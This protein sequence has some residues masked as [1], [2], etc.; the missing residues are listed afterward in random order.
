M[1]PRTWR[2]W[3]SGISC[4]C[5]AARPADPEF[6]NLDRILLAATSRAVPRAGGH[7]SSSR[8]RHCCAGTG[9][10][11]Q[12]WTFA[13]APFRA[14]AAG[15]EL[16]PGAA[17]RPGEPPLGPVR[18]RGELRKLGIRV[19]ATTI[20]RCCGD[21]AVAPRRRSGPPGSPS[22]GAGRGDRRLRLLHG[23]DGLAADAV[24]PVLPGG[25]HPPGFRRR[26]HDVPDSAVGHP[27]SPNLTW[28][29]TIWRGR[30]FLLRDRDAK[31]PAA[32]DAVF[33]PKPPRSSARRWGLQRRTRLPSG[34]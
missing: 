3:C 23:G 16:S 11:R 32:F 10:V 19:G 33:R 22:S 20:R 8:P 18:I 7:R 13:G 24:C 5:C 30:S 17:S 2:S 4:E 21:P 12:K 25:S 15:P 6:T 14:A 27:A 34:G 31:F 1:A 26:G 28:A 29:W 9:A